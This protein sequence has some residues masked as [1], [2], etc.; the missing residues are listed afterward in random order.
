MGFGGLLLCVLL[1]A[2]RGQPECRLSESSPCTLAELPKDVS[3]LILPGGNTRCIFSDSPKYGFQVVPGVA[4]KLLLFFQGG[5]ACFNDAST[6]TATPCLTRVVQQPLVGV[7]DRESLTNPFRDY[8]VVHINY[9]S[10]DLHVG[11]V[12]RWYLDKA[13][14]RVEQRGY[15][16]ALSALKWTR[17]HL[18]R[19]SSLVVAGS[20]TG[21]LGAQLWAPALLRSLS[22]DAASLLIDSDLGI[23]PRH[24]EGPLLT[25]FG[26]CETGLFSSMPRLQQ[27]CTARE[28]SIEE[29]F[30]DVAT[31]FPRVTTAAITSTGDKMQVRFYNAVCMANML[32]E[33]LTAEGFHAR[34]L[35]RLEAYNRHPNFVTFLISG[36]SNYFLPL[37]AYFSTEVEGI[38]LP[39]WLDDL[40][41]GPGQSISSRCHGSCWKLA[42]TWSLSRP[43]ISASEDLPTDVAPHGED[44]PLIKI[45][46]PAPSLP[47]WSNSYY[48]A[49]VLTSLLLCAGAAR[50]HR[51]PAVT[52]FA[53]R[54][55]SQESDS[56]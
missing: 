13:G 16:N 20:S 26:A 24:A 5:G 39:R 40:P 4:D 54:V 1:V 56:E 34:L 37:K 3:T 12:A 14:Q 51:K 9:C 27:R 22:F 46:A 33:R 28:L 49:L 48:A 2:A 44:D 15:A 29:V 8:T 52:S 43:P 19:L 35:E 18:G 45:A 32:P 11:N 55:L 23:F 31:S 10:G 25:G 42:K 53:S 30:E 6:Q 38:P 50:E 21:A 36:E 47:W 7:F 17:S 41:E